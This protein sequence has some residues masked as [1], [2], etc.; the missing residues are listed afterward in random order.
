MACL[1]TPWS[2][3]DVEF[4]SFSCSLLFTQHLVL[5]ALWIPCCLKKWRCN[6]S[7]AHFLS[8]Q[9]HKSLSHEASIPI[10]SKSIH[11]GTYVQCEKGVHRRVFINQFQIGSST[12]KNSTS[13]EMFFS[14]F[15]FFFFSLPI[16]CEWKLGSQTKSSW[17]T[18]IF[19]ISAQSLTLV[20]V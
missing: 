6:N 16:L 4:C 5:Q 2:L 18:S 17:K 15:G 3:G 8:R 14:S 20:G 19:F 11:M 1:S 10:S 9:A 13:A 7:R 12:F